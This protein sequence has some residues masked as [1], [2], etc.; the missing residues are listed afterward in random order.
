MGK[1]K[2]QKGSWNSSKGGGGM[3]GKGTNAL[4]DDWSE[5]WSGYSYGYEDYEDT[6]LYQLAQEA[7]S[8]WQVPKTTCKPTCQTGQA[9]GK[10][11]P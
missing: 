7:Q 1:C 5:G 11:I 2:G 10:R 4:E 6:A 8:G 3:G 9:C